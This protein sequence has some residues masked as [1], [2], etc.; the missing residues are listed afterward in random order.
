MSVILNITRNLPYVNLLLQQQNIEVFTEELE[1]F[2]TMWAKKE[3][4]FM[5]LWIT[6]NSTISCWYVCRMYSRQKLIGKWS[7]HGIILGPVI[8]EHVDTN[9][10]MYVKRYDV[11]LYT[12]PKRGIMNTRHRYSSEYWILVYMFCCYSHLPHWLMSNYTWLPGTSRGSAH[13]RH[14]KACAGTCT[15][16]SA[17]TTAMAIP[18]NTYMLFTWDWNQQNTLLIKADIPKTQF[19][20]IT[21]E[22]EYITR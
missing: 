2:T 20:R 8:R 7:L 9:T 10:N 4:K 5:V 14:V 22:R 13:K 16:A 11:L 21:P 6:S 12:V 17:M 19:L 15:H 3:P 1:A 18:V